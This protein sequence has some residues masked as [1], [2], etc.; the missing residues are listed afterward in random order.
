MRELQVTRVG[1]PADDGLY[2]HQE[3]KMKKKKSEWDWNDF[4]WGVCDD[5][6]RVDGD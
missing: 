2:D 6:W 5:D 4:K 1:A 3:E